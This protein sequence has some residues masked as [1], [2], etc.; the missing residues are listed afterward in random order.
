MRIKLD[1][2]R[3]D[4]AARSSVSGES[5]RSSPARIRPATL[6]VGRSPLTPLALTTPPPGPAPRRSLPPTPVNAEHPEPAEFPVP[7]VPPGVN[8]WDPRSKP[9]AL[10]SHVLPERRRP[11][12]PTKADLAM[13]PQLDVH[14]R[15]FSAMSP[16]PL[17]PRRFSTASPPPPD[18]R[19]S[20]ASPPPLDPRF[21][22]SS[23]PPHNPRL[24]PAAAS[25]PLTES[26]TLGNVLPALPAA[27]VPIRPRVSGFPPSAHRPLDHA[28]PEHAT[29]DGGGRSTPVQYDRYS[30]ATSHNSRRYSNDSSWGSVHGA[31][32]SG[33]NRGSLVSAIESSV[34]SI[35]SPVFSQGPAPGTP[36]SR[37][38]TSPR[39]SAGL[40]AVAECEAEGL[41]AVETEEEKVK[42]P[43]PPRDTSITM[44][45]SFYVLKGF[46]EGAKEV[47]GGELGVKKVKKPTFSGSQLTAKCTKCFYE[48]DWR[49]IEMDINQSSKSSPP[50]TPLPTTPD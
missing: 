3:D 35:G 38:S 44:D 26:P 36:A 33:E 42:T 43:L 4:A 2:I 50:F 1:H 45:S 40:Q 9:A 46:C 21:Y 11:A 28:I 49:E 16:P 8:P 15:R 5:T 14:D 19:F 6:S 13:L 41:I 48:L 34:G 37:D 27:P 17:D 39:D 32:S 18:P 23:P 10:R 25:P 24:S 12:A 47:M 22:T 30:E 7:P 20:T 31:S 29:V